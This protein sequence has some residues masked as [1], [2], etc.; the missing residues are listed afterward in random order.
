MI[1]KIT[2]RNFK[3]LEA[4]LPLSD[5]VIFC[6]PNNSGKTTA[7]QAIALWSFGLKKWVEL[8]KTKA[9]K[10]KKRT[11]VAINRKDLFAIPVPSLKQLWKN[12]QVRE[13]KK[14]SGKQ[15]TKNIT[16][17]ISVEGIVDGK[18]WNV[19]LE[20]DFNNSEACYVRPN[21]NTKDDDIDLAIKEQVVFLPPMAG[22]SA[23]EYKLELG[24]INV[25]I[26]QGKTADVLRNL[27]WYV[28]N[29][30]KEKWEEI[31]ERI[32]NMFGIKLNNPSYEPTTGRIVVTYKEN[33]NE[34][35]LINGGRG[36]H[37]VLLLLSY[38]Y[39]NPGSIVLIDEPDAHLEILRQKQIFNTLCEILNEEKSQSIIATH[40]EAV[41]NEA[42]EKSEVIAFLGTPHT[43]TKT[44]QLIK[45]LTSIGFE[46]YL[47]A[48]QKGWVLYL[49]GSTDLD[50]LKSFAKV[51]NH[52]VQKYLEKP[53]T[54]YVSNNISVARDHFY[55][56]KEGVSDLK[57]IAL[58]DRVN[59]KLQEGDLYEMMWNRR[60]IENYIPLPGAIER[61]LAKQEKDLF[62]Q[63]YPDIMN[64]IIKDEVPPAALK[65]KQHDFW[66]NTKISDDFLDKIFRIFSE[67]TN[68]PIL[69]SKK[70]YYLL[71]LNSKAEELESEVKE[72]LDEI[73]KVAEKND[74]ENGGGDWDN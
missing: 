9:S 31:V 60:E 45:S 71:A 50:L 48:Q 52:P 11:G 4:D 28:F 66:I 7:L 2:I 8:K 17:L 43:I 10:A 13:L 41:L 5:T 15:E 33:N 30:K 42:F 69:L 38:I 74:K 24:T 23:E 22:L 19:G 39:V 57:G 16:I 32:D 6:G 67:K 40:S 72:K 37:Q 59:T 63:K 14:E 36:F 34:Y 25:F 21:K 68:S 18:I 62:T 26:G 54:K 58:Y 47:L 53:F 3:K 49:E 20:F 70:D 73:Y 1:T 64:A 12:L 44:S 55:G 51:L 46:Q 61:Y 65:D 35:D 29:D 56:L 27:C